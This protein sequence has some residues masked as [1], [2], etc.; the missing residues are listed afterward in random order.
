MAR[1]DKASATSSTQDAPLG[2]SGDDS[3]LAARRARLRGTLAKQTVPP[4]A[5]SPEPYQLAA[6]PS[7][8]VAVP[9]IAQPTVF[10]QPHE[11]SLEVSPV[12]SP[13]N[14]SSGPSVG[15]VSDNAL[16]DAE[17]EVELGQHLPVD[18]Q[19]I[20]VNQPSFEVSVDSAMFDIKAVDIPEIRLR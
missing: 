10:D 6:E 19:S 2:K 3:S 8:S 16:A 12:A 14:A 4:D 5:Y 20:E 13:K 7:Q 11:L 18:K 1:E 9:V 17:P 15:A